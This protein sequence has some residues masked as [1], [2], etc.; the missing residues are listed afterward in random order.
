MDKTV[1]SNNEDKFLKDKLNFFIEAV[2]KFCDRCGTPYKPS[3][4]NIIQDSGISSIIHFSCS[5]CKSRHI[6][7][8]MRPLGV[9]SRS[10][11][12]TDLDINEI[13]EFAKKGEVSSDDVLSIYSRL[14]KVSSIKL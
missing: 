12:N 4:L 10:P 14:E 3:N 1:K 6:A 7:T 13:K 11:I 5:N 2:A 8:F 9:S